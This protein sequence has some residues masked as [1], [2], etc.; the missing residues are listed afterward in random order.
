MAQFKRG[1]RPR[2]WRDPRRVRQV[3]AAKGI[4][5]EKSGV[6][7]FAAYVATH[8][9]E[10]QGLSVRQALKA[11]GVK[12]SYDVARESLRVA[13]VGPFKRDRKELN[14]DWRLPNRDLAEIH[15]ISVQQIAN[16]RFRLDAGSALWDARGGRLL[17]DRQ[18]LSARKM[19]MQRAEKT[20][21]AGEKNASFITERAVKKRKKPRS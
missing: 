17:T 20:F 15:G 8:R 2:P 11:S 19:E 6:Q 16:L 21:G 18:Y 10:L 12:L 13:G 3:R 7:K 14:V 9:R 5:P 1:D 4:A